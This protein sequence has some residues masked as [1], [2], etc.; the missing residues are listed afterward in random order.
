MLNIKKITTVFVLI[1]S[2]IS[3]MGCNS[4][5]QKQDKES[6]GQ[7]E[8]ISAELQ[9]KHNAL[10]EKA[11]EEFSNINDQVRE[12]NRII[13]EQEKKLSE[14]QEKLLDTIQEKRVS[15]NKRL[16]NIKNISEEEWEEFQATFE[17]DLEDIKTKLD[18][19]LDDF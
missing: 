3:F 13:E 5:Q 15:V 6:S 14:E 19:V 4:G 10:Q 1:I 17:E 18:E 9:E 12:L 16:N 2:L 7:E 8:G 11:S